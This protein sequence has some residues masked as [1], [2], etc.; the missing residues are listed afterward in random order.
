MT[1]I[2]CYVTPCRW[3]RTSRRFEQSPVP[4]S[5]QSSL[6]DGMIPQDKCSS[7]F[8]DVEKFTLSNTDHPSPLLAGEKPQ[9]YFKIQ[10]C[11]NGRIKFVV[12]MGIILKRIVRDWL[13]WI[14]RDMSLV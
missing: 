10:K 11:W 9:V 14:E 2:I 5:G 12:V 7:I 3:M 8:R 13:L 6:V 1:Q 4:L